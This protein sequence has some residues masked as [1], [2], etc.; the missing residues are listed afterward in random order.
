MPAGTA[1]RFGASRNKAALEALREV[2]QAGRHEVDAAN[3]VRGVRRLEKSLG[4]D[5]TDLEFDASK[6]RR[7][8]QKTAEPLD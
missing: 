3:A 8:K 6:T 4:E 5:P 7:P 1:G 2:V